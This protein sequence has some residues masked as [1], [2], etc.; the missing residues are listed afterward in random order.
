MTAESFINFIKKVLEY[1]PK[2]KHKILEKHL[3]RFGQQNKIYLKL[4][5]IFETNDEIKEQIAVLS[6]NNL[7]L[8]ILIELIKNMKLNLKFQYYHY[9]LPKLY[10]FLHLFLFL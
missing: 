4:F 6:V 3:P 2:I 9:L 10:Y 7:D 5:E 1:N 8:S